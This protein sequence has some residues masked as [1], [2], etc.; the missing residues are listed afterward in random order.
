MGSTTFPH[1]VLDKSADTIV[2]TA[3]AE[4]RSPATHLLDEYG[5]LRSAVG[6]AA[7]A[8]EE[9]VSYLRDAMTEIHRLLRAEIQVLGADRTMAAW[10]N[11]VFYLI[12]VAHLNAVP[13][14]SMPSVLQVGEQTW[15][16]ADPLLAQLYLE[17]YQLGGQAGDPAE[18]FD[19]DGAYAQ[20]LIERVVAALTPADGPGTPPYPNGSQEAAEPDEAVIDGAL[21][22]AVDV[23]GRALEEGEADQLR[24]V[25]RKELRDEP[26]SPVEEALYERV[27]PLLREA[28][29]IEDD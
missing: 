12:T 5:L 8:V 25:L 9:Q 20:A 3:V 26:L 1:E 22:R 15:Y 18:V 24:E 2:A 6:A 16:A 14:E 28:G 17:A 29:F 4:L 23:A 13:A 7:T 27:E 11:E 10:E 21:D 19:P